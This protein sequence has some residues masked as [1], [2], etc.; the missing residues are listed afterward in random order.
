MNGFQKPLIKVMGSSS[1]TM[2]QIADAF[3]PMKLPTVRYQVRNMVLQGRLTRMGEVG[4][5]GAAAI[6][7]SL[8]AEWAKHFPEWFVHIMAKPL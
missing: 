5:N 4:A 7:Y 3:Y 2:A 6:R 1:M 8:N